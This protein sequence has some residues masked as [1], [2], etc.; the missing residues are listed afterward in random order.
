MKTTRLITQ[1]FFILTGGILLSTVAL[2]QE[3]ADRRLPPA[4]RVTG[5]AT[6]K[7]KP[8][9]AEVD[10]GVV[11]QASTA[12]A[13]GT[14]NAQQTDRVIDELRRALGPNANIKTINYSLTPNYRYPR[15]GGQPTITGYTASNTVQVITNDLTQVGKLIDLSTQSGAN[16]IQ[17]LRF[18]LKDDQSVRSQAL[19]EA[20][21]KARREAETLASALGLRI[22]RVLL[23]E[24]TSP[25]V[26]PYYDA[27]VA[28]RAE[29]A[30]APTPVEPGTIDVRATVTLTVE[31]AQ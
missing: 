29:A 11:T 3:P 13:A 24:E 1:V 18:T 10:I 30:A 16:N 21:V 9:Q 28:M 7:A 8:D 26:R 5:E 20:A 15:E 19:R 31:V 23:V 17:G 6:V 4:I 12:Q 25:V 14:Q 2:G 27:R 22:T